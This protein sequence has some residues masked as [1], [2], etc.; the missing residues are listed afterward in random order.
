M[1]RRL[2]E[3]ADHVISWYQDARE[4]VEQ[5]LTER[6]QRLFDA[7]MFLATFALLAVPLYAVMHSGWEANGLRTGFATVSAAVLRVLGIEIVQQG[8]MLYTPELAVDVSRDSTGWKSLMAFTAL[9]VASRRPFRQKLDGIVIGV[10]VIAVANV[11]RIV[12]MVYAV[13]VYSVGYELLHTVLWR[14][15]LTGVVFVAWVLWLWS[16]EREYVFLERFFYD[17]P[18]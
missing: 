10:G 11:V 9:V 12:S 14:W 16:C 13:E 3:A 4:R 5:R 2:Q 17:K 15:G 8:S 1:V 18:G 6:Q 7:F